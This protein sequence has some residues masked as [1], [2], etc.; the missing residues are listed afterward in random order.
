[1]SVSFI[2]PVKG[3]SSRVKDKNIRPFA[4]TTLLDVKLRVL[5]DSGIADEILV[6]SD[7]DLVLEMASGYSSVRT[8]RR[9]AYYCSDSTPYSE[10]C[11]HLI[12]IARGRDIVWTHVTSPLI[13]AETYC[14]AWETYQKLDREKFDSVI[15]MR[16]LQCFLWNQQHV[17]MNYTTEEHVYSQYLDPI[18]A[19]DNS[20]FI[21]SKDVGLCRKFNYGFR[22]YI[23]ETPARETL[24]I[25]WEEDFEYAEYRYRRQIQLP[26]N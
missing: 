19:I 18:Y 1:M 2:L 7:S 4:G 16:R 26:P 10:V 21:V 11:E 3:S 17:P 12:R 6:S 9:D 24:D 14:R 8:H 22:P 5:V 13:S 25:D 23:F 15:G 20:L